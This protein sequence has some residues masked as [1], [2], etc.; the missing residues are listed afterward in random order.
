M[1]HSPYFSF[2]LTCVAQGKRIVIAALNRTRA[3][4]LLIIRC[5]FLLK[6][7]W[8]YDRVR[9]IHIQKTRL[10]YFTVNEPNHV[11]VVLSFFQAR[12]ECRL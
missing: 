5:E 6:T 10:N 9:S 1:R 2:I 7:S 12:G 3:Y 4:R 8:A 11:A